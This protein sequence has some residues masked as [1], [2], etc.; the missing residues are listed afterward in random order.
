MEHELSTSQKHAENMLRSRQNI[1]RAQT[2]GTSRSYDYN[3]I[4]C[5]GAG[6][7]DKNDESNPWSRGTRG[8]KDKHNYG[9]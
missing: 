2:Y 5:K 6:E 3:A 9:G 4:N 1:M 7:L 8:T